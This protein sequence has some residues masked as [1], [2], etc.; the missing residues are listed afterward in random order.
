MLLQAPR[1]P[2]PHLGGAQGV[3]VRHQAPQQGEEPGPT[4]PGG[5]AATAAPSATAT[6]PPRYVPTA[7]GGLAATHHQQKLQHLLGTY[8]QCCGS[9]SI[10]QR[11]GYGSGSFYR[12]AKIQ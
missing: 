10:S 11:Y 6:A 4:A 9:G 7:P 12:Q 5:L 3:G 8:S 2:D 1:V